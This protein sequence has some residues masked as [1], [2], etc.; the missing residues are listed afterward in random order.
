M[1]HTQFII[2]FAPYLYFL[3]E[4][5]KL[6]DHRPN[7]VPSR[8]CRPVTYI[9]NLKNAQSSRQQPDTLKYQ[10]QFKLVGQFIKT[11][12][13]YDEQGRMIAIFSDDTNSLRP[14]SVSTTYTYAPASLTI[15]IHLISS[16]T[17]TQ[18]VIPLNSRGL[19]DRAGLIYDADGYL[20]EDRKNGSVT[21][22]IIEQGN[23]VRREIAQESDGRLIIL[24]RHEYDLTRPSV[25]TVHPYSGEESRNL[26]VKSVITTYKLDGGQT[27]T[28]TIEYKYTFDGQGRPLSRFPVVD[29]QLVGELFEY[30]VSCR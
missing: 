25:I 15:D 30:W 20:V 26:L 10:G 29:G 1:S 7:P 13:S 14:L 21:R 3:L 23:I 5:F 12:A 6:L 8:L 4:A 18:L 11:T 27:S 9:E 28:R 19:W 22:Q 24:E 2:C 17:K 16:G